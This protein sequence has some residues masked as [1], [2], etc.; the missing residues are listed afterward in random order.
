M[1]PSKPSSR[2]TIHCIND[3]VLILCYENAKLCGRSQ[4]LRHR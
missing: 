2:K 3:D 1:I 4:E